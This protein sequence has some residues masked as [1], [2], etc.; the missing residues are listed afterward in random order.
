MA[1]L[2]PTVRVE[3]WPLAQPFIISRGAI[4]TVAVVVVELLDGH[5]RGRGECC[6]VEHFGES[7]AGVQAA[8]LEILG[9][10]RTVADWDQLHDRVPAGAARNAVDCAIWDLRAKRAGVGI[11]ALLDLA[12]LRP[13]ETVFTISLQSP[14]A[15]ALAAAAATGHDIL[16][17]KLGAPGDIDRV[18][19]IRKA[20]PDKR[21]VVDVNEAWSRADLDVC[22]PV[23]AEAGVLMVEQPLKAGED[24]ALDGVSRAIPLGADESCHTTADLDRVLGRYDVINIKLDKT[25]GLTEAL[26]LSAA[27]RQHGLDT[28]VGCMLGTSLAMA[29]AMVIAQT[30]RFVDLDAPLLIGADRA[31]SLSYKDGLV[32]PPSPALWG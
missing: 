22:L 30:C 27:A 11:S 2:E 16:K 8:I 4:T 20:V 5:L 13:V 19:A 6:P 3:T 17:L 23:M 31:P 18:R 24:A 26:R 12:P 25:G 1:E 28:M 29:P 21:L 7:V 9:Q 15:M 32:H 10:L 14:E